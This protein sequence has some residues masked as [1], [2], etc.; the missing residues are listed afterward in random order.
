MAHAINKNIFW[1]NTFSKE[2]I[3]IFLLDFPIIYTAKA[4]INPNRYKTPL[5]R[6][7]INTLGIEN[8]K[9]RTTQSV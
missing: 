3:F 8:I 5:F 9:A 4:R 2:T 6:R 7:I 1:K